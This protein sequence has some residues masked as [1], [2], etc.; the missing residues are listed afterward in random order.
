VRS[1][2]EDFRCHIIIIVIELIARAR[3]IS[4]VN[5]ESIT[6][7]SRAGV[8]EIVDGPVFFPCVRLHVVLRAYDR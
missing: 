1:W 7:G 6:R 2:H 5:S 8:F 4:L 3:G